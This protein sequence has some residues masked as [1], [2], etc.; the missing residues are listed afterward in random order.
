MDDNLEKLKHFIHGGTPIPGP[1]IGGFISV[2]G[3]RPN[4]SVEERHIFDA[5]IDY[6]ENLEKRVKVLE[7]NYYPYGGTYNDTERH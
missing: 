7:D 1:V 6:I 5:L 3:H 2:A 4:C